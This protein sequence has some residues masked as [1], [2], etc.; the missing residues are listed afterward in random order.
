M[1]WRSVGRFCSQKQN[2]ERAGS[3]DTASDLYSGRALVEYR[4]NYPDWFTWL[5]SVSK[6]L[7]KSVSLGPL[8]QTSFHF[9]FYIVALQS[10][11]L[12]Q[13]QLRK[14]NHKKAGHKSLWKS[15]RNL[16]K[17]NKALKKFNL[18]M[19]VYPHNF[20]LSLLLALLLEDLAGLCSRASLLIQVGLDLKADKVDGW[21]DVLFVHSKIEP[22]K[23]QNDGLIIRNWIFL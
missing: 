10:R 19:I 9:T 7:I 1:S 13:R 16:W 6:Y 5:S 8:T 14:L 11:I 4:Q 2:S 20:R 23:L 12:R 22:I 21:K 17:H 15:T 3:C 18:E